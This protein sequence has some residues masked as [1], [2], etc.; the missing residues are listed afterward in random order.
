[1]LGPRDALTHVWQLLDAD[2]AALSRVTLTG[3]EPGL[4]SSFRVGCL[5]QSAIAASALAASEV[6]RVRNRRDQ[7]VSVD[8]RHALTEFRS[9]R[10]YTLAGKPPGPTWDPIAGLYRTGDGRWVRLHTNFPHHRDG[11]LALLG[12]TY[13]RQSVAQKLL[14]WNGADFEDAVA[15][16]GLVATLLRSPQ[17]WADHPQGRAVANLPLLELVKLDDSA[18]CPLGA[19]ARPLSGVRVLDLTRILA[20]PVSTRTL[21]AHGADVLRVTGKHLP[22]LVGLDADTGRGKLQAH[23][24]LDDD[25]GRRTLR[26][27][28]STADIFVQGYRPGGIAARGFSPDDCAKLRPGI[29]YVSLSAWGHEGPWASRRG[30]DSLVQ[31]ATGINFAEAEAGGAERPKELPCQALDHAAGYLMAA[32]ALTALKRRAETGGSWLVRISLAQVGHWLTGMGRL[33]D[34]LGAP[35]LTADDVRDLIEAS[36]SG[37]GPMTAVRHSGVLSDTPPRWERPSMPLGAHP[38]AWPTT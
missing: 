31:N 25:A 15:E 7:A 12:A 8:M 34:G 24:D 4:P 3:S 30:Y 35:D 19:S 10:H 11:I 9:E 16:R 37:H 5:A 23:I 6:D 2:P 13:D 18:P 17:E 20:G 38:P 28:L 21:A 1:M 14:G 29:I 27:L 32:G 33:T 22:A 26:E 36:D